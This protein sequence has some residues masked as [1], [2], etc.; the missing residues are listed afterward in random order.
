MVPMCYCGLP[1]VDDGRG[2]YVC[3]MWRWWRP[4]PRHRHGPLVIPPGGEV[5][6]V[7]RVSMP[8][9]WLDGMLGACPECGHMAS[10]GCHRGDSADCHCT[11]RPQ[12][13]QLKDGQ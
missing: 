4:W 10:A 13:S 5:E 7:A 6:M 9:D 12:V 1:T 3:P 11:Q 8:A 2:G